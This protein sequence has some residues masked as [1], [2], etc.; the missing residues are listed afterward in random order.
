M[1]RSRIE[2]GILQVFRW[3]AILRIVLL[4]AALGI[5]YLLPLGRREA[6]IGPPNITAVSMGPSSL[7]TGE[8]YQ[9]NIVDT[10]NNTISLLSDEYGSLLH[11][12][13]TK[14]MQKAY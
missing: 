13:D 12:V 6:P 4:G 2:P 1:E 7:F 10:K 3:F 5:T 9:I 8:A 14:L 11:N